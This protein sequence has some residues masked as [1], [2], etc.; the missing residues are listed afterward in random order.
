MEKKSSQLGVVSWEVFNDLYESQYDL[1]RKIRFFVQAGKAD[2][3]ETLALEMVGELLDRKQDELEKA[4]QKGL[5]ERISLAAESDLPHF[6]LPQAGNSDG[7][8]KRT[9]R[10]GN[11]PVRRGSVWGW[12]KQFVWA[13]EP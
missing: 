8:N 7:D 13:S 5:A 9:N 2:K 4:R 10:S 11:Q 1:I 3:N 12:I 6:R